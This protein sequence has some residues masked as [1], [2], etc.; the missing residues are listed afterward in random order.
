LVRTSSTPKCL[1]PFGT[2]RPRARPP[3]MRARPYARTWTRCG[4][5][6][7]ASASRCAPWRRAPQRRTPAEAVQAA[8]VRAN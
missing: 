3:L 1:A 5:R 4:P 6:W 7:T 2:R 8:L